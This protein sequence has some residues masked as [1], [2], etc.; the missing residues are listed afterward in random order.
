[1]TPYQTLVIADGAVSYVPG[2]ELTNPLNDI[3][4]SVADVYTG[5]HPST[6]N[7]AP[8]ALGPA[9]G[10]VSGGSASS[11]QFPNPFNTA[12]TIQL[13][14]EM[15]FNSTDNVGGGPSR[16]GLLGQVAGLFADINGA[17]LSDWGLAFYDNMVPS[18][19]MGVSSGGPGT[20]MQLDAPQGYNDG[21]WHHVVVTWDG[22][23]GNVK[24]YVDAV[25][26]ASTSGGRTTTVS[27]LSIWYC[28]VHF[29]GWNG[30]ANNWAL[31]GTALT[32]AQITSHYEVSDL[33][34]CDPY[35]ND[36]VL[37][38]PFNGTN[39]QTATTD[40]SVY[41]H[42]MTFAGDATLTT[43]A[44]KFGT[45][46]LNLPDTGTA[47]GQNVY[48]PITAG[49]E[50]DILSG[51]A[52][53]TIEGFFWLNSGHTGA[54][55]CVFDYGNDHSGGGFNANAAGLVLLI[56]DAHV[57]ITTAVNSG[58]WGGITQPSAI[59]PNVW[60]HFAVERISG[61]GRVYIDG[62]LIAGAPSW[63][64]FTLG[65]GYHGFANFGGSQTFNGGV[66]PGK[67]DDVRVTAGIA[68]YTSIFT[69]PT[70]PSQTHACGNTVPATTGLPLGTAETTIT[71]AGLVVGSIFTEC[72]DTIP[73]GYVTRTNPP[74]GSAV[75]SGTV[76]DIYVADGLCSPLVQ[77]YGKFAPAAAYKPV[78]LVDAKGIKPRI[79]RPKENTTVKP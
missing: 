69:P 30:S 35:F 46:S 34:T 7:P 74:G 45:A 43:S 79:Y 27:G 44:P 39:G 56:D 8:G 51:S 70:A 24:M 28:G 71:D 73:V 72:S 63:T 58:A 60:H 3:V 47:G 76:V 77:V 53:F 6:G 68:R 36:V 21:L 59:T 11:V 15:W 42:P 65:G 37:L 38:L 14:V 57:V 67:V 12:P 23:T 62:G 41:A 75:G 78:L 25:L 54:P 61:L 49:G 1:M 33:S 18:W 5:P 4:Q 31:Y 32:Q 22:N 19:G 48:T 9:A 64:G 52:D 16:G 55:L 26:V 29:F 50:L 20:D 17:G 10:F 13:T 40:A 2:N 66:C